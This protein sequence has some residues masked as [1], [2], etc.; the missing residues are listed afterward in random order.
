MKF[1]TK[2]YNTMLFII[3]TAVLS[4]ADADTC[5][6]GGTC[7]EEDDNTPGYHPGMFECMCSSGYG[8]AY[9]EEGI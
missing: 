6:N 7:I 4:C 2:Q 5:Q 8:G 3:V 9:C 1:N